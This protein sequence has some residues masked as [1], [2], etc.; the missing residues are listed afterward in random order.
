MGSLLKL[1]GK[2]LWH[3]SWM[4]ISNIRNNNV[5]QHLLIKMF[6]FPQKMFI[7]EVY[8]EFCYRL[9]A[10]NDVSKTR[11]LNLLCSSH[12]QSEGFD[13][14]GLWYQRVHLRGGATQVGP[15]IFLHEER[16]E[17]PFGLWIACQGKWER[18]VPVYPWERMSLKDLHVPKEISHIWPVPTQHHAEQSFRNNLGNSNVPI[19]NS[20]SSFFCKVLTLRLLQ[21]WAL[22]SKVILFSKF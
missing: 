16:D 19:P 12:L 4:E 14:H 5:G 9:F 7:L 13:A 11:F 18:I 17:M 6:V 21:L 1:S 22:W 10:Y 8:F 20:D 15:E 3:I 2:P